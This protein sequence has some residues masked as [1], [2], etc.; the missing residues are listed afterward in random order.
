MKNFRRLIALSFPLL[1]ALV[2][3]AAFYSEA[4]RIPVLVM[5]SEVT[6]DGEERPAFGRSFT[7]TLTGGLLK[8]GGFSVIDYLSNGP[9][10]AEIAK[11]PPG[12]PVE[13]SAGQFGQLTGAHL[14][15][16]PR[17][18][19][20]D[21]YLRMT[22]KKIRVNDG[23]VLAVYETEARGE[24]ATMFTLADEVRVVIDDPLV[25]MVKLRVSK[26][27]G[28]QAVAERVSGVEI[29]RLAPGQSAF[30]IGASDQ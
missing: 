15:Y 3:E 10:A 27:D 2:G 9:I 26:I 29:D 18:V 25:P 24:R 19:V 17:L 21:D 7:D 23:A 22:V 14:V 16:V 12:S 13:R 20:E 5:P 1:P 11:A 6:V 8:S 28:H 30:R 4:D